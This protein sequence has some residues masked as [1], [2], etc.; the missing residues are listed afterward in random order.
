MVSRW[1]LAGERGDAEAAAACLSQDV[2]LISPLTE[3]FRFHGRD[4]V[5]VL[6]E[7]AFAAVSGIHFHT[8]VSQDSTCA[9]FYRGSIGTR[10]LEEAQLLRLDETGH[11]RELTLFIR[12]LPALT[13]LMSALGPELARRRGN[14]PLAALLAVSTAPLH[15]MTRLGDRGIVPLAAPDR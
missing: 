11:I 4:Q 12:S 13:A 2:V 14:R 1:R 5:R 7:A 6:L 10:Q 9:L 3:Q 8:Q 15:A